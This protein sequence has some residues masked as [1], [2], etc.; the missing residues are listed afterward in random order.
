MIHRGRQRLCGRMCEVPSV[1]PGYSVRG[2]HGVLS[3]WSPPRSPTVVGPGRTRPAWH[4]RGAGPPTRPTTPRSARATGAEWTPIGSEPYRC[5]RFPGESAVLSER[6][7]PH[8][9][10]RPTHPARTETGYLHGW[11]PPRPYVSLA[12]NW[13]S[14][15]RAIA[16]RRRPRALPAIAPHR[17][18]RR[19]RA[20]R[21]GGSLRT[22]RL[23]HVSYAAA[24]LG[25]DPAVRGWFS[26]QGWT[27]VSSRPSRVRRRAGPGAGAPS[28]P[29][30]RSSWVPRPAAPR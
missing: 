8:D 24:C 1:A 23:S 10:P 14:P 30:L 25:S 20:G 16:A 11:T 17:A 13:A 21:R 2:L 15:S 19:T 5:W 12:G 6:A 4:P 7:S 22:A 28:G 9:R 26:P 3:R 18:Q 29:A 27:V